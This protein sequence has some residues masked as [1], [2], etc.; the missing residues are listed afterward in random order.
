MGL[1]SWGREGKPSSQAAGSLLLPA[2]TSGP[3]DRNQCGWTGLALTQMDEVI[4]QFALI[5]AAL[6]VQIFGG[7]YPQMPQ[8]SFLVLVGV[9]FFLISLFQAIIIWLFM[10]KKNN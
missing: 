4:R 9:G 6:R 8:M 3:S 5:P 10:K 1:P 2:S 7:K